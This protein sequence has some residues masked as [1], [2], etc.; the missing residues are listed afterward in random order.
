MSWRLQDEIVYQIH[1]LEAKNIIY[2]NIDCENH[3]LYQIPEVYIEYHERKKKTRKI[4]TKSWKKSS[5]TIEMIDLWKTNFIGRRDEM[6]SIVQI[7]LRLIGN[8]LREIVTINDFIPRSLFLNE[9][10]KRYI[11]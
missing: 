8:Y 2:K 1:I 5:L 4:I 3:S 6:S 7:I 9:N 10:I 11:L